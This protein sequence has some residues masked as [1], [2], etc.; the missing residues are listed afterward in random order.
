[1]NV[2]VFDIWSDYGHFRQYN[3]TVSPLTFSIP[4]RTA[5]C[6]LLAA[7]IGLDKEIYQQ[8]FTKRHANIAIRILKPINKTRIPINLID[9]EKI[10]TMNIIKHRIQTRFEFL[11]GPKYRIYF[12]H[13]NQELYNDMNKFLRD[14]KTVYT[15]C[16]GLSENVA[17]FCFVGEKIF[18]EIRDNKDFVK[19]HSIIPDSEDL[20]IDIEEER[21]Y[22]SNIVA[23]EMNQKRIVTERNEINF[24]RNGFPISAKVDKY[25]E[26]GNE[27]IIF[28]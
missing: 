2:L 1:M 3:T 8:F 4:P 22:S 24:E 26:C 20:Y 27:R 15:P 13:S 21:E 5:I 28:L 17:N 9:T 10:S 23:I 12:N 7:I 16:L 18:N 25:Y 11:K 19:I 6:G 14:H